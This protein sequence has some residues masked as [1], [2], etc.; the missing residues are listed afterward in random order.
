M[1]RIR[2]SSSTRWLLALLLPLSLAAPLTRAQAIRGRL[3]NPGFTNQRIKATYF[4]S[5]QAL[6]GTNPYGAS[7]APPA[8]NAPNCCTAPDGCNQVNCPNR[9]YTLHPIDQAHLHWSDSTNNQYFALNTMVQAG[10]NVIHMSSWGD[11]TGQSDAWVVRAAPMQTSPESHDQLFSAADPQA[12]RPLLM[13]PFLEERAANSGVP[14]S[15]KDEFPTRPDG[16]I[17]PGTISQIEYFIRHYL[18]NPAHP[19]WA[20]RW[21][22]VYDR[23]GQPRYAIG[24][25]H[26]ASDRLGDGEDAMFAAGFDTVATLV[27]ND[28][29]VSVGF[30]LDALPFGTHAQAKFYASS[31]GTGPYLAATPSVL[32]IA[33]FVPEVYVAPADEGTLLNWKRQWSQ[34][35]AS[36]GVPF[37]MDVSSG[38]NGSVV[39]CENWSYGEDSSW[40]CGLDQMVHDFGQTGV[41]FNSWNGYTEGM[42]A[43]PTSEQGSQFYNWLGSLLVA[44]VY[45]QKP[46][47]PAPRNGSWCSPY[48]LLEAVQNVPAGGTIGLLPTTTVPFDA[49]VTISRPC[50]LVVFEG[51]ATIGQ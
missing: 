33:C 48:T 26:A 6:D 34:G 14:W 37:L 19:E 17:A 51:P 31:S 32:A 35:W 13:I 16:A 39:F 21:A 2:N 43:L 15:F 24:I 25:I 22:Q 28:T 7:N 4:F 11:D 36:S 49:P 12:G 45:A 1:K 5:G 29:R 50:R 10:V 40:L 30:L 42:V 47:A 18:Q 3:A 38:Y 44:D 9:T 23:N 8:C 27:S 41:V 20:A 46:D